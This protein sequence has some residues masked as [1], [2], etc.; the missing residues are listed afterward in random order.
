MISG[1]A[2]KAE[3]EVQEPEAPVGVQDH[4]SHLV[5]PPRVP[6][7]EGRKDQAPQKGHPDLAAVGVARELQVEAPG[8]GAHVGE[9]RLVGQEDGRTRFGQFLQYEIQPAPSLH[10][11]VDPRNV[12]RGPSP[13]KGDSAVDQ[14]RDA[15]LVDAAPHE[16][17]VRQVVVVAQ[18]GHTVVARPQV[19]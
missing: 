7:R 11:V 2:Q 12:Q 9:V 18:D 17:Y 8:G 4:A 14:L 10:D 16:L 1:A 6:L 3:T 13:L 19:A 15:G 5:E